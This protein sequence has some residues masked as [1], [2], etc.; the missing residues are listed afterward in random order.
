M[1]ILKTAWPAL[2]SVL[3]VGALFPP[4]RASVVVEGQEPIISTQD[5]PPT[6]WRTLPELGREAKLQT[7]LYRLADTLADAYADR[8]ELPGNR[9]DRLN[10]LA[11]EVQQAATAHRSGGDD[12]KY[13][14]ILLWVGH[15]ETRLCHAPHL[16][17]NQDNGRA[18]GYFQVWT[19]K[20][21][22]PYSADT[23]MDMMV[24]NPGAWSLPTGEPWTGYPDADRFIREHPFEYAST[25]PKATNTQ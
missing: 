20:G 15:R 3:F 6:V 19:W 22:D 24:H 11:T 9:F 1:Q 14:A 23:A 10:K 21:R 4:A 25:T 13:A 7:Y 8:K 12:W 17:G 2:F 16:L 5:V 18:H